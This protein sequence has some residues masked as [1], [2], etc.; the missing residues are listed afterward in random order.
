[1][2]SLCMKKKT[3]IHE[4][5]REEEKLK[6]KE[7]RREEEK[8]KAKEKRKDMPIWMQSSKNQQWEIRKPS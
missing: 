5:R 4:K 6:V 7:K 3:S 1:M 8:L 2:F